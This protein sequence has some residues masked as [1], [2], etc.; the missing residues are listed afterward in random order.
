MKKPTKNQL[1]WVKRRKF[2]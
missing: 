2:E 1:K